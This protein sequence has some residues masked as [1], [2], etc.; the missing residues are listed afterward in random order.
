MNAGVAVLGSLNDDYLFSLEGLPRVG[1]TVLAHNMERHPG[2]KGANQAAA[3]A[4]MGARVSLIGAVGTDAAGIEAV[5]ALV[6]LGVDVSHVRA[7][8]EVAT[9]TAIVLVDGHG[10]NSIVVASGA[11]AQL[12]PDS[13]ADALNESAADVLLAQLEV[14]I[15][16]VRG[17]FAGARARAM[18]TVLNAAPAVEDAHLLLDLVDVLVVNETEARLLTE[19]LGDLGEDPNWVQIAERLLSN[20]GRAVVITLGRRGCVVSSAEGSQELP[21]EVVEVVDSTG[22]GDVFCGSLAALLAAGYGVHEAARI[23]VGHAT[24]AVQWSGARPPAAYRA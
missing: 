11:N 6:D 19:Q 15:P 1:E 21:A 16:V 12:S 13:V 18:V 22:A 3:A 20:V 23:S 5:Q 2:G 7:H 10:S 17:A 8:D 9:G 14:P 24:S 4:R